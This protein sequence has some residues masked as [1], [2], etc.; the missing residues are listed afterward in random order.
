[1][2]LVFLVSFDKTELLLTSRFPGVV[3]AVWLPRL[4]FVANGLPQVK[5]PLL[6][7]NNSVGDLKLAKYTKWSDDCDEGISKAWIDLQEIMD[8]RFWR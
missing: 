4:N 2:E 3:G 5:L 1:M 6:Q 7:M 8:V